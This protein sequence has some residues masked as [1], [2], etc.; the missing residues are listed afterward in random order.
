MFCRNFINCT[1]FVPIEKFMYLLVH[2]INVLIQ[3]YKSFKRFNIL[4][5]RIPKL[6][7]DLNKLN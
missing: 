7:R 2:I 3:Y 4:Y 6:Y 1:N 5:L